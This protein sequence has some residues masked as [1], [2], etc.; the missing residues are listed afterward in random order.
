LH[1]EIPRKLRET[2]PPHASRIHECP[3][4]FAS[5]MIAAGVNVKAL[6]TFSATPP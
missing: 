1:G 6:S 3:H 2:C 5:L 4:T